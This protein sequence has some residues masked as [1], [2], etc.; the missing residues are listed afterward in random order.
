MLFA[1][2]RVP[3]YA[4]L[5]VMPTP[6]ATLFCSLPVAS[7]QPNTLSLT[8]HLH[9]LVHPFLSASSSSFSCSW[10]VASLSPYDDAVD[11]L[12]RTGEAADELESFTK[13]TVTLTVSSRT[14]RVEALASIL[15]A[16]CTFAPVA[17]TQTVI[18]G[19][20]EFSHRVHSLAASARH[21]CPQSHAQMHEPP[22]NPLNPLPYKQAGMSGMPTCLNRHVLLPPG[23]FVWLIGRSGQLSLLLL[24]GAQGGA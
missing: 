7:S 13:E 24:A 10:A 6:T 4:H 1:G 18:R 16:V 8:A 17:A 12:A 11:K 15:A 2:A 14:F 5:C 9:F 23:A 20:A 21:V 19:K 22:L 3:V